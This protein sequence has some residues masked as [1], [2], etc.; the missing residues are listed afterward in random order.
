MTRESIRSQVLLLAGRG[1]LIGLVLASMGTV[2]PTREAGAADVHVTLTSRMNGSH[3]FSDGTTI[4][5]WGFREGS[6][7]GQPSVPGPVI[8]VNEGDHVFLHFTNMSPMPHTIH[9]H[10]LDVDQQNDGVPQ[11]SFSVPMMGSYTYEFM[12]PHAGSYAYHCH[13]NT[14]IHLQ[15]GMY[16]AI[17]VLPPD[18]SNHAWDGGP[19]FDFERTWISAE[20]DLTWNQAGETA[21][22]TV[23]SPDIF[24]LNGKDE[25]QI[26]VDPY[27]RVD[28][29]FD[30]VAL[31]RVGNMGYQPVRY[32]FDGLDV[33]AVASDGR[34][35]PEPISGQGLVVA[36]GERYDLMVRGLSAGTFAA[37]LEYLDL[38]D[39]S[40]LGVV[41]VPITVSD[42]PADV[43][44]AGRNDG[45][46][47]SLP[48]PAPFRD[49][50]DFRIDSRPT[51]TMR[52]WILDARGRL[53]R[54]DQVDPTDW[55]YSWD[56][57]DESG[58][59]VTDGVY[60]VR[61]QAGKTALTRRVALVH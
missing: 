12:A 47:V 61:F 31:V 46:Q 19:S 10:G 33:E 54:Q 58:R 51:G 11:T 57:H 26:A 60:F 21:D 32:G 15:M 7:M 41:S 3:T 5:L 59:Q 29:G 48:A 2:L 39:G 20:I 56:G 24:V 13:V 44:G 49:Q 37:Q 45:F 42:D 8:T 43:G 16:G 30:E 9:P 4:A 28:L 38:Y 23:Y 50:V 55:V 25:A 18:G 40:V 35:L 34:P 27:T 1:A 22:F 17:N 53:I 14:V 52:V 6:G 36:P